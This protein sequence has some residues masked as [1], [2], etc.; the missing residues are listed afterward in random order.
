MWLKVDETSSAPVLWAPVAFWGIDREFTTR[1]FL[2]RAFVQSAE[3]PRILHRDL[4][5]Q[6]QFTVHAGYHSIKIVALLLEIF[7]FL[8]IHSFLHLSH[9]A[10]HCK[11]LLL[12]ELLV[13]HL[14]ISKLSVLFIFC[15]VLLDFV[16]DFGTCLIRGFFGRSRW[17][18]TRGVRHIVILFD[19]TKCRLEMET[20]RIV[21]FAVE[22]FE[23]NTLCFDSIMAPLINQTMVLMVATLSGDMLRRRRIN[24]F[25]YAI[26]ASIHLLLCSPLPLH[27]LLIMAAKCA[28]GRWA[29]AHNFLFLIVLQA[30]LLHLILVALITAFPPLVAHLFGLL[31]LLVHLADTLLRKANCHGFFCLFHLALGAS[32]LL[33]LD[34]NLAAILFAFLNRLHLA[35]HGL[36]LIC[37]LSVVDLNSI[38]RVD[39]QFQ[40]RILDFLG[41]V[42]VIDALSELISHKITSFHIL[43]ILQHF[44]SFILLL[45]EGCPLVVVP[46]LALRVVALL[47]REVE[48]LAATL[49]GL[50]LVF[51]QLGGVL[52]AISGKL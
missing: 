51:L 28:N 32:V 10:L 19:L 23:V 14:L 34:V 13:E 47:S 12:L 25:S 7:H 9:I 3:P 42:F 38:N 39:L 43:L 24:D 50:N 37:R 5:L 20:A 33:A 26:G 22:L 1:A 2:Y 31:L 49:R 6:G 4:M 36:E 27:L 52:H 45:E 15:N 30:I 41:E 21:L 11:Y 44:S 48:A 46:I 8:L 17:S 29:R 18:F 16:P 35:L 40:F